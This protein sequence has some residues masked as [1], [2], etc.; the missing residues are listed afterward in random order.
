MGQASA[1]Q[2]RGDRGRL[3]WRRGV[4]LLPPVE[5]GH[6]DGRGVGANLV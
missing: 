3:E 4:R 5:T 1:H 6:R 2:P